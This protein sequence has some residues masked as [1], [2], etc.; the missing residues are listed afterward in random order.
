MNEGF[1]KLPRTLKD[2]LDSLLKEINFDHRSEAIRT[3]GFIHSGLSSTL[4]ELDR[5]TKYI[6]R[7]SRC[8]TLVISNFVDQFGP[9]V[10]PVFFLP[11]CA[12]KLS[13]KCLKS[14]RPKIN[15][16]KMTLHGLITVWREGPS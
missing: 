15:P 8:K 3:V 12:P 10:L 7:V 1:Y 14:F 4:I 6:S 5:P 16:M 11:G 2:M 13:R 9:T